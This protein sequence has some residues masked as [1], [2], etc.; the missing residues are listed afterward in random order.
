[1]KERAVINPTPGTEA[2]SPS[3]LQTAEPRT[4]A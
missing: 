3:F 4:E 2:T 1:M